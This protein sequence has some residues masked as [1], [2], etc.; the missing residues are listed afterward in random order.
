MNP[1][2]S[3]K[4]IIG[5]SQAGFASNAPNAAIGASILT[6]DIFSNIFGTAEESMTTLRQFQLTYNELIADKKNLAL[7][8][9]NTDMS[10]FK[11]LG[12]I[13]LSVLSY[14]QQVKMK[15]MYKAIGIKGDQV[16]QSAGFPS[17]PI[18]G[19]ANQFRRS[20][21]YEVDT[22]ATHPMSVIYRELNF[23]LD[24]FS[25]DFA[26]YDVNTRNIMSAAQVERTAA[27]I[28]ARKSGNLFA[29]QM[30]NILTIDVESTGVMK[31]IEVRS[32]SVTRQ[33]YRQATGLSLPETVEDLTFGYK[34]DKIGGVATAK[35]SSLVESI[36][37]KENLHMLDEDQVLSKFT[38]LFKEMANAD[39]VIAHNA[40]FDVNELFKTIY[41]LK[42]FSED[43]E[44]GQYMR[45]FLEKRNSDSMYFMDT[46]MIARD[47]V[48]EKASKLVTATSGE[49][50]GAEYA[51]KF[52]GVEELSQIDTGG[53]A[54]YVGVGNFAANTNLLDLMARDINPNQKNVFQTIL[55]QGSHTADVDTM[56]QAYITKYINSG[57]LDF[58]SSLNTVSQ[59]GH[60]SNSA[61]ATATERM[62][63]LTR[64]KIQQSAQL[65]P[66]T[67]V[68]D[69]SSEAMSER[70]FNYISNEGLGNVKLAISGASEVD[71]F[72]AVSLP[73]TVSSR[74]GHVKY[75][76]GGIRF[77]AE[78][79]DE[80]G[81]LFSDQNLARQ[82][83][84]AVIGA[85]RND[86]QARALGLIE[87]IPMGGQ[88]VSIN[89]A[90]LS[91]IGTGFDMLSKSSYEQMMTNM[92]NATSVGTVTNFNFERFAENTGAV[93]KEFGTHRIS[94]MND[95]IQVVRGRRDP[96]FQ[97]SLNTG[98]V[99]GEVSNFTF[100]K[101]DEYSKLMKQIGDPFFFLD[102]RDK[103]SSMLSAKATSGIATQAYQEGINIAP[104]ATQKVVDAGTALAKTFGYASNQQVYDEF[105]SQLGMTHFY[106][107]TEARV[108]SGGQV[109]KKI[110][111]PFDYVSELLTGKQGSEAMQDMMGREMYLSVAEIPATDQAKAYQRVN[112]ALKLQRNE[113]QMIAESL[114]DSHS[115]MTGVMRSDTD[116]FAK[117][118]EDIQNL[119][120]KNGGPGKQQSV[121]RA[122]VVD[123]IA[124]SLMER[125]V[126]AGYLNTGQTD[127][128]VELIES[129]QRL[130][131]DPAGNDVLLRMTYQFLDQHGQVGRL[132]PAFNAQ[133]AEAAGVL[134]DIK[135]AGQKLIETLDRSKEE[136]LDNKALMKIAKKSR[137]EGI[138]GRNV[139]NIV[140]MY[141]KFKPKL[142]VA[143]LGALGI[144]VGYYLFK[145]HEE[146]S[147]YSESM[148]QQPYEAGSYYGNYQIQNSGG[149]RLDVL[150]TAGIV[151]GLDRGKIGHNRMGSNKY[152]HLYGG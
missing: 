60:L 34:T 96:T 54:T 150:S 130:G 111:L 26:D 116:V 3:F 70:M 144:G 5:K 42:N 147:F 87:D 11:R 115:Q 73:S 77:F 69:L 61:A 86:A 13:D 52:F 25:S 45:M 94:T 76:S 104:N 92:A 49:Q 57:E 151:G 148:E 134:G 91:V 135:T 133:A 89:R 67:R 82:Q 131:K 51:K 4:H 78:G 41:S 114:Y 143:A 141:E 8:Y 75:G 22:A 132:T 47:Y 85:A 138:S 74:V 46:M 20:F 125:D 66:M 16:F 145:K 55:G 84:Q 137:T 2:D 90:A 30:N 65:G 23:S 64:M 19:K 140:E 146:Q 103:L 40:N 102:P 149:S 17:I 15:D 98:M 21:K 105:L 136:F 37:L 123:E 29:D 68:T 39:K 122:N 118:Q 128:I 95:A 119:M 50:R 58:R 113:A 48:H 35:N 53:K 71:A 43:S 31:D 44:L 59:R 6:D 36:A 109:A 24:P 80:A 97:F 10:M 108:A 107:Q 83:M 93:F 56:L 7:R 129:L 139:S 126:V 81:Y 110:L 99:Q 88:T 127:E 72:G 79:G 117:I 33:S 100:R 28:Q 32:V 1:F 142:G 120:V 62:I 106:A 121:I 27:Q 124:Q 63:E 18:P 9:Q 14:E 152:S 112:V 38:N 12:M 101:F